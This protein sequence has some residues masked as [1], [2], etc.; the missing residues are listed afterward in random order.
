MH[1]RLLRDRLLAISLRDWRHGRSTGD[2]ATIPNAPNVVAGNDLGEATRFDVPDFDE[3]AVEQE[4]IWWVPGHMLRST[5][6]LDSADRTTG[7]TMT[8]NIKSKLY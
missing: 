2:A 3:A 7:I 6:P 1:A 8:I 5:L 4:D